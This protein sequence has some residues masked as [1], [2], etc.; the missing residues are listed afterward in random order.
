MEA[1]HGMK[2]TS[3][4][5]ERF[6]H[7]GISALL[8]TPLLFSNSFL[9][10]AMAPKL[11]WFF[12]VS[13]VTFVL[14][15]WL[16]RVKPSSPPRT[17]LPLV[18]FFIFL[19]VLALSAV[20]GVYP[21]NSFWGSLETNTSVLVWIHLG[22]VLVSLLTVAKTPQA[23]TNIAVVATVIG[24]SVSVLHLTSFA[25]ETSVIG[26]NSG[27]TLG[28][29][30]FLGTYLLFSLFFAAF[31]TL[32]VAARARML[33]MVAVAVFLYTLFSSDAAA[34][35]IGALGGLLLFASLLLCA[36]KDKHR[37]SLGLA[38]IFFLGAAFVSAA[39]LAIH[40]GNAVHAWILE[41]SSGSR[42][43]V[44]KIAWGSFLEHPILGWG[45]EN[46]RFAFLSHFAPCFGGEYCGGN[47]LFD[48]AHN[49]FLDILV[50]V[51]LVGLVAYA[52]LWVGMF[53]YLWQVFRRNAISI[54]A[55]ALVVSVLAAYFVQN[56]TTFDTV[57]S[58]LFFVFVYAF[59][60]S[61]THEPVSD[62]RINIVAPAL[63][64]ILL[65]VCLFFFVV[66]PLRGV[67]NVKVAATSLNSI[68]RFGAY[69]TA[70]TVSPLGRD[71][72]RNFLALQTANLLWGYDPVAQ[73]DV[74]AKLKP[75]FVEEIALAK[76]TL[77]D[78]LSRSPDD[79]RGYLYLLKLLQVQ[80][81]LYD[82]DAFVQAGLV[83]DEARAR[84]P[85]QTIFLWVGVALRLE[86]GDQTGAIEIAKEAIALAPDH[87]TTQRNQTL[88]EAYLDKVTFTIATPS[89]LTYILL[90]FYLD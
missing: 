61:H 28:N 78:T 60:A 90:Q 3:H 73:A 6:A 35:S 89:E 70:V 48:R 62:T 58:L 19:V 12:F 53:S 7:W 59:V 46:F 76:D 31:L 32:C 43:V 87:E 8:A 15:V 49:V 82:Q 39:W 22:L 86:Q 51:G 11:L 33:G 57:V 80:C 54:R 13:E 75:Y 68:V 55:A 74:V 41:H 67:M 14:C 81:R 84:N 52:A 79:L 37:R 64:T 45:P 17:S 85:N 40:D 5:L 1:L 72:R 20:L 26:F 65:P 69:Q 36:S 77:G 47:I 9:F 42:F 4:L 21:L 56:L 34:A 30:G 44:A 71:V 18:L 16:W 25:P 27:S 66:E 29:S 88:L 23:W 2:H 50:T 10:P 63:V 83:L 24:L 38:V